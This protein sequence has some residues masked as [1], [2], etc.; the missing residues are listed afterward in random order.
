M[1]PQLVNKIDDRLNPILVKEMRQYMQ[2]K[3]LISLLCLF[4]CLLIVTMM[5]FR[6][7]SLPE[8]ITTT[9]SSKELKELLSYLLLVFMA[10]T[11]MLIPGHVFG[12]TAAE[13]SNET[14]LLMKTTFVPP[15]QIVGGKFFSAMMIQAL[16]FS[17]FFPFLLCIYLMHGVDLPGVIMLFISYGTLTMLMTQLAVLFGLLVKSKGHMLYMR[18]LLHALAG[19]FIYSCYQRNE[20]IIFRGKAGL[21]LD[22]DEGPAFVVAIMMILSMIAILHTTCMVITSIPASNRMMPLRKMIFWCWLVCGI[23]ATV[24]FAFTKSEMVIIIRS[25]GSLFIVCMYCNF[26]G[27]ERTSLTLRIAKD[28]PSEYWARIRAYPFFTGR[29]G[30]LALCVLIVLCSM[31]VSYVT[32]VLPRTGIDGDL[33]LSGLFI[34]WI[35]VTGLTPSQLMFATKSKDNPNPG[36]AMMA[37]R[38]FMGIPLYLVAFEIVIFYLFGFDKRAIGEL[39]HDIVRFPGVSILVVIYAVLLIIGGMLAFCVAASEFFG[40]FGAFRPY[41]SKRVLRDNV[42]IDE[43]HKM[44][45]IKVATTGK[46]KKQDDKLKKQRRMKKKLAELKKA[47]AES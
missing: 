10:T 12:R 25:F 7:T 11:L 23:T 14:M 38:G 42:G 46:F 16:V 20:A 39:T 45:R 29:G 30:G 17:I 8:V 21:I 31:L 2:G 26:S 4:P 1:W 18:L 6:N 40:A 24:F 19:V 32:C 35:P 34:V 22:G 43:A 5:V 47:E 33:I 36:I 9:S 13:Q 37:M 15:R 28:I 27:Y 41:V 3:R 44:K